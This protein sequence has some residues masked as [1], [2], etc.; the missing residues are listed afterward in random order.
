MHPNVYTRFILPNAALQ[1]HVR[2]FAVRNFDTEGHVF[3]KALITDHEIL[4]NFFLHSK[5]HDFKPTEDNQY[6][7]NKSNSTECYFSGLLTSTKGTIC[8][9][10]K[11]TIVTIHFKPTGFYHIFNIS[12][13][14]ILNATG[15]TNSIL[16]N[17]ISSLYE[18]IQ[19][20]S[21]VD[22]SVRLLEDYLYRKLST[23]KRRYL[24]A[25]IQMASAF[26]LER[27]GSYSIKK[28]SGDC[29]MTIQTLET[30]FTDQVGIDPKSFCCM[31]RF[32]KA[33]NMKVYQPSMN[34]TSIAHACSFYDQMHLIKEFKK[35]TLL[36]PKKF[37]KLIQPP[38]ENFIKTT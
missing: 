12:P 37:M 17:E 2:Y 21:S 6:V 34:W 1:S 28:L 25:S 3:D 27:H 33:V 15:E 7:H 31:V 4:I 13:K 11:T 16:S 20:T 32:N 30:Q 9:K 14:E 5:L 10:G 29:N 38:V 19:Y 22:E 26:L 36:T 18:R 35:F 24:H 23:Q 8:F